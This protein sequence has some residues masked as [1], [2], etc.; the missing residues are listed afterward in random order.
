MRVY[1]SKLRVGHPA[2]KPSLEYTARL[3]L[4]VEGLGIHR[5]PANLSRIHCKVPSCK[6][7][8][9]WVFIVVN[10]SNGRYV[11]AQRGTCMPCRHT[12][13]LHP[14]GL[15]YLVLQYMGKMPHSPGYLFMVHG[16]RCMHGI[17]DSWACFR[18]PYWPHTK[19]YNQTKYSGILQVQ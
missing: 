12:A 3:L 11:S 18:W 16:A 17:C 5:Q 10:V 9:V 15:D 4:S 14:C 1:S 2:G 19:K 6:I 8:T 13:S 7:R